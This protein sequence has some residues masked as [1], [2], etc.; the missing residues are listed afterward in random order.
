MSTGFVVGWNHIT[1]RGLST[2]MS[3]RNAVV[4]P[5]T[6]RHSATVM[7]LH[8][9]GDT[10]QGWAPVVPMLRQSHIKFILPTAPTRSVTLNGGMPMPAWTD[11]F[12]LDVA[13]KEDEGGFTEAVEN[14]SNIISAE[15]EAGIPPER[16]IV[17]GFSQGGAVALTAHLRLRKK[18][19][20]TIVLSS[21]L[22]LRK[23]YPNA[24]SEANQTTPILMCHVR[25]RT[26]PQ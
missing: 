22:P 16:I 4:V 6:G 5:A 8:G 18:I 26:S 24:F 7:F 19:A 9:L 17:G 21:W 2:R 14:L 23:S 3:M 13:S 10:G 11:V 15:V 1:R 25:T 20:G 12:G